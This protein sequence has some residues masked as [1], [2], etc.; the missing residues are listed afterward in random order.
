M[1]ESKQKIV[2]L[3]RPSPRAVG[4]MH[5]KQKGKENS[6]VSENFRFISSPVVSAC[7]NKSVDFLGVRF[8]RVNP[9]FNF[10]NKRTMP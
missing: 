5:C 6:I 4:I 3:V 7:S 8:V 1:M 10:D 9:L 2:K